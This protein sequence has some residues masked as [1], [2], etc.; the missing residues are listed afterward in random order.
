[1]I[2]KIQKRFDEMTLECYTP[3]EMYYLILALEE[4]ELYKIIKGENVEIKVSTLSPE[5]YD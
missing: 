5:D 4:F 2:D 3:K 1:M